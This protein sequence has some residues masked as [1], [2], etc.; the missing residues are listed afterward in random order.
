MTHRP[1]GEREVLR[2]HREMAR[3][4]R[5]MLESV[6]KLAAQLEQTAARIDRRFDERVQVLE[7]LLR[8][9]EDRIAQLALAQPGSEHTGGN[10]LNHESLSAALDGG[11][12][13]KGGPEAGIS[14]GAAAAV[15]DSGGCIE[16]RVVAQACADA[17][18]IVPSDTP[19][20]NPPGSTR[21]EAVVAEFVSATGDHGELRARVRAM[22]LDGR[23]PMDIAEHLGVSLGEVELM[24]GLDQFASATT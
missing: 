16:P 12:V 14:S 1:M 23:R 2:R 6:T 17:A 8:T 3:V 10:D 21:S 19:R 13:I 11:H 20:A 9:A 15:C 5:E 24:L 7:G 22:A 18:G 4:E